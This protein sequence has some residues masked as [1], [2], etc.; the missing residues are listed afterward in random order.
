MMSNAI[1]VPCP[2]QRLQVIRIISVVLV[3]GPGVADCLA[4]LGSAPRPQQS[5]RRLHGIDG[6]PRVAPATIACTHGAVAAAAA[7]KAVTHANKP[8]H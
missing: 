1:I 7:A 4:D 8:G 2:R 3:A 6:Q 5:C